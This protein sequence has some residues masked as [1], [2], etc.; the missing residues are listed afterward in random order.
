MS[1]GCCLDVEWLSDDVFMSCGVDSKIQIMKLSSLSPV[2]TLRFVDLRILM[3]AFFNKKINSHHTD[4]VNQIKCNSRRTLLAS[5][6]DDK[7]A[8]VWDVNDVKLG[9][10]FNQKVLTLEG[11]SNTVSTIAWCPWGQQATDDILAT[12]V[13]F[14]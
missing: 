14:F 10:P 4:E 3:N 9:Q 13:C 2:E 11:H 12:Y 8:R 5:C 6:S 1:S 7:T